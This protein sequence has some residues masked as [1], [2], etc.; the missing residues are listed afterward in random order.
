M[1]SFFSRPLC[2]AKRACQLLA[3]HASIEPVL[4]GC[5]YIGFIVQLQDCDLE[6]YLKLDEAVLAFVHTV[7]KRIDSQDFTY[8]YIHPASSEL[9]SAEVPRVVFNARGRV[10]Y[11]W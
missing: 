6:K 8:L 7:E 9:D 3:E 10:V 2:D 11:N 4:E 1:C 5:A